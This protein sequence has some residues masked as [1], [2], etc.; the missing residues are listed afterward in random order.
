MNEQYLNSC[1]CDITYVRAGY[2][3]QG[4]LIIHYYNH[5]AHIATGTGYVNSK[6]LIVTIYPNKVLI[7]RTRLEVVKIPFAK[8]G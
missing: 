2:T 8:L 1:P 4:N 6:T 3:P 5:G 7:P